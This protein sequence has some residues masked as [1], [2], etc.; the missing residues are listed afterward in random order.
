M[1]VTSEN[2]PKPYHGSTSDL[3]SPGRLHLTMSGSECYIQASRSRER[4]VRRVTP[5]TVGAK[6]ILGDRHRLT[7]SSELDINLLRY[8]ACSI[9]KKA[10]IEQGL[11]VDIKR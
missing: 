5:H 11:T 6:V 1:N 7:M 3:D 9:R 10:E 8:V 2:S 4:A